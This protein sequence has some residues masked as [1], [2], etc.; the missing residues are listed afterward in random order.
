MYGGGKLIH[1]HN[2]SCIQSIDNSI[3]QT[4]PILFCLYKIE[5]ELQNKNVETQVS[6]NYA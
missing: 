4:K 2:Q 5:R 1:F 6:Q 3:F